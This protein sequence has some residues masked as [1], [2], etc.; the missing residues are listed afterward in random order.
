MFKNSLLIGLLALIN[1]AY[2]CHA[3]TISCD[4]RVSSS[5]DDLTSKSNSYVFNTKCTHDGSGSESG[6]WVY[7]VSAG[8]CGECGKWQS[9][10]SGGYAVQI[11]KAGLGVANF[12]Y[13]AAFDLKYNGKTCSAV[14]NSYKQ[15]SPNDVSYTVS[16]NV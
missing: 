13:N 10:G 11:H 14:E 15:V 5:L 9:T 7:Y 12:M 6:S 8:V 2:F 4:F 1:I 3:T 16:C